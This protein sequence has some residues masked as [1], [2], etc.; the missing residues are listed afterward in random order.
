MAMTLAEIRAK[1]KEQESKKTGAGNSSFGD[2]T[3]YPHWNIKEGET[4]R[5]RFLPDADPKKDAQRFALLPAALHE[6]HF[7]Q[8]HG[9]THG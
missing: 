2:G 8:G 6:G 3:V 9:I 1:L 5:T 4:C 7:G